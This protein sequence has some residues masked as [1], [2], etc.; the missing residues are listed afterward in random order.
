M[1]A[2]RAKRSRGGGSKPSSKIQ[3]SALGFCGADDS[4]EP[5]L[6][7]AI[8]AQHPWVEW[9]VLFREEKAGTPR[10]AS[11]QW[12][13][14]L[15][16]ANPDRTMKL[17]AHL[18]S[19]RVDEL[20]RGDTTFV[21]WLHDE[22]GFKRVQVNATSANGC[23]V[24]MFASD[25]GADTCVARLREAAASVP[26]IEFI[27]QRN[28]QTRPLWERMVEAPPANVAMLFD[29][30]MGLG[31]STTSWPAPPPSTSSLRFG[32]AGGLSPSNLKEQMHLIESTAPVRLRPARRAR[33][34]ARATPPRARVRVS[35]V[36]IATA[37]APCMT[38]R[39]QGRA[40]WVDMESSLRTMLADDSDVFDVNKA[41]K[42]VRIIVDEGLEPAAA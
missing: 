21:A 29:D 42:C 14:S 18:C 30:S 27:M 31:V 8:S 5:T 28:S 13:E 17:A 34:P 19:W 33:P 20:L 22:I 39:A 24:G 7:A 41:M 16:A 6:L 25:E 12:L 1:S 15:G 23:D 36:L 3:L 35:A 40:L 4:V 11:K 2:Q 9:G 38:P 26:H 10:Y 32:Y 37:C